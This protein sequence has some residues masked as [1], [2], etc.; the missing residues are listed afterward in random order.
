ML[1]PHSETL[2]DVQPELLV[3]QEPG[4]TGEEVEAESRR[5]PMAGCQS[6]SP[7]AHILGDAHCRKIFPVSSR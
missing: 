4:V 7:G 1:G 2:S 5:A 3:E 6:A